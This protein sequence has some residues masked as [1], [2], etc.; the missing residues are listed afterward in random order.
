MEKYSAKN[1]SYGVVA[2]AQFQSMNG[3]EKFV[4]AIKSVGWCMRCCSNRHNYKYLRG[5]WPKVQKGPEPTVIIWENLH[6]GGFSRCIRTSFVTLV[7][8]A[9][10]A[11]S[12][13]GIVISQY[14]Q[15]EAAKN[16]D[17]SQCG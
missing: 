1:K 15:T 17:I 8:I 11:V 9:L 2:Y 5:K 12:V 7:T 16:F 6:I 10:L 3:K 13:G 14:Y 4:K